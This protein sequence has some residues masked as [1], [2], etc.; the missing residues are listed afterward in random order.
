MEV[1]WN[2]SLLIVDTIPETKCKEIKPN[3]FRTRTMKSESQSQAEFIKIL[4]PI[5]SQLYGSRQVHFV[6]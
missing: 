3:G 4:A 1:V 5:T 6:C 2:I